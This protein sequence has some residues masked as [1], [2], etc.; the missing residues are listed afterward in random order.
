MNNQVYRVALGESLFAMC[1]AHGDGNNRNVL[2]W[3]KGQSTVTQFSGHCY[4]L[5][6]NNRSCIAPQYEEYRRT[7]V[8][9][10]KIRIGECSSLNFQ[11]SYLDISIANWTDNGSYSCVSSIMSNTY[12]VSSILSNTY[13]NVSTHIIVG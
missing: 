12:N 9:S 3:H 13:Y 4:D 8:K 7:R 2:F 11:R 5:D 1:E 6:I 10:Y